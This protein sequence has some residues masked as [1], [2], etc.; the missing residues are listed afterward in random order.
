M[1]S[2]RKKSIRARERE[3][4][5]RETYLF[6][7]SFHHRTLKRQ[8]QEVTYIYIYIYNIAAHLILLPVVGTIVYECCFIVP[9]VKYSLYLSDNT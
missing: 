1:N 8:Q 3:R 5:R 2:E 7:E 4:E 6:K 9:T